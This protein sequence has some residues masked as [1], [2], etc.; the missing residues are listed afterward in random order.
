ML[1]PTQKRC[2]YRAIERER[3][4]GAKEGREAQEE[5]RCFIFVCCCFVF[6]CAYESVIVWLSLV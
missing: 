4:R 1:L 3:E 5:K 2:R 6:V